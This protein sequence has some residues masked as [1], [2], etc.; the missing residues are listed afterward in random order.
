MED[1][2]IKLTS[3][4]YVSIS[5]KCNIVTKG[6]QGKKTNVANSPWFVDIP[7]AKLQMQNDI[8]SH[9]HGD[10]F[11][12]A[13]KKT[14]GISTGAVQGKLFNRKKFIDKSYTARFRFRCSW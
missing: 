5:I 1:F 3:R 12:L 9:F 8:L 7:L 14:I 13:Q 6:L 2:S 11:L 10:I 4:F